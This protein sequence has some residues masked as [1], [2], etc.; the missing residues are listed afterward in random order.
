MTAVLLNGEFIV[1]GVK[2]ST[3]MLFTDAKTPS[4]IDTT[5][6]L[7]TTSLKLLPEI[8]AVILGISKYAL[9]VQPSYLQPVITQYFASN[10]SE[11]WS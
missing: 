9:Q 2:P 5:F 11:I 10:K 8:F 6:L 4:S 1:A 7:N 3:V